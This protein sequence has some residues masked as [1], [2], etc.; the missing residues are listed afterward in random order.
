MKNNKK[1]STINNRIDYSTNEVTELSNKIS[2][3]TIE[4]SI[5]KQFLK[6]PMIEAKYKEHNIWDRIIFLSTNI[7]EN[8]E[9]KESY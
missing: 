7:K 8:N 1:D 5:L 3:L 2:Y 9:P 6:G 4:L